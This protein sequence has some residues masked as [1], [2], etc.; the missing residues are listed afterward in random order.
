MCSCF[1][2]LETYVNVALAYTMLTITLQVLVKLRREK[3]LR[4]V[5]ED[6]ACSEDSFEEEGAYEVADNFQQRSLTVTVYQRVESKSNSFLSILLPN[7][8]GASVSV[9]YFFFSQIIPAK[10]DMDL[11]ALRDSSDPSLNMVAQVFILLLRFVVPLLALL[12][13][14]IAVVFKYLRSQEPVTPKTTKL[15]RISI[16]LATSFIL[17]SSMHLLQNAALLNY[18]TLKPYIAPP[19][20]LGPELVLYSTLLHYASSLVRP[21]FVLVSLCIKNFSACARRK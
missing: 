20:T 19:Y 6:D 1:Y 12:I 15:F 13:S 8:L 16:V 3:F 21:F 17:C 4:M 5:E 9:P 7:L 2:G 10:R 11:C 14:L 18:H